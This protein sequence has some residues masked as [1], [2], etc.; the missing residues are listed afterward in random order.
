MARRRARAMGDYARADPADADSIPASI[1]R[2]AA[3]QCRGDS[4]GDL[5]RGA[6]DTRF[7][8]APLGFSSDCCTPGIRLVGATVGLPE[9]SAGGRLA[10]ARAARM[11]RHRRCAG[12][13]LVARAARSAWAR[14]RARLAAAAVFGRPT[15]AAT[16]RISHRRARCRTGTRRAGANACP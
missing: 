13:A 6:I 10:T 14:T 3:R 2:F 16:W 1:D 12:R 11:G 7:R 5:C 8:R 4:R 15:G 9:P